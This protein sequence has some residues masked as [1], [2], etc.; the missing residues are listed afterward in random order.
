MT[1]VAKYDGPSCGILT[2]AQLKS[3][4]TSLCVAMV[5]LNRCRFMPQVTAAGAGSLDSL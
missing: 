1:Q 3:L 4:S 5:S 2:K